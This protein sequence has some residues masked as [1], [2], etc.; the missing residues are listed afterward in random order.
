M[1]HK[2]CILASNKKQDGRCFFGGTVHFQKSP[3]KYFH[4]HKIHSAT[5]IAQCVREKISKAVLTNPAL[6]PTDISCGKGLRFIPST[7]DGASSHSGKLSLKIK[8]SRHKM[9]FWT[10]IGNL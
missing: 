6:T 5:K 2:I 4:N 8:K 3:S 10:T 7:V 9:D 1:S